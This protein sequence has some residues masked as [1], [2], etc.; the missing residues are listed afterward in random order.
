VIAAAPSFER[1]AAR[2]PIL[3]AGSRR[4]VDLYKAAAEGGPTAAMTARR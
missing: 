1:R 2:R 3:P 4:E